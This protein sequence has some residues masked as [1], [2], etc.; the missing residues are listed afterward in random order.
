MHATLPRSFATLLITG[1]MAATIIIV[2][3]YLKVEESFSELRFQ[4]ARIGTDHNEVLPETIILKDWPDAIALARKTPSPNMSEKE[5][6]HWE[7]LLMYNTSPLALR[8][9]IGANRLNGK[10]A[11]AQAWANR[12]CWLLPQAACKGL[13][14]EWV[15]PTGNTSS[16][17][18]PGP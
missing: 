9:V 17:K 12:A 8:K 15:A 11:E 4:I 16:V 1:L 5:I 2:V 18:Q 7:A 14:D 10:E 6:R 3:D 13:I